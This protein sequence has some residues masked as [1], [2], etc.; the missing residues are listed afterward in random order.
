MKQF[1]F[2]LIAV[3]PS[4]LLHAQS[5]TE[6]LINAAVGNVRNN[7]AKEATT[8]AMGVDSNMEEDWAKLFWDD[9]KFAPLRLNGYHLYRYGN[10]S[11]SKYRSGVGGHPTCDGAVLNSSLLNYE[12][13][14]ESIRSCLQR[15]AWLRESSLKL[16]H[17]SGIN[18]SSPEA[19]LSQRREDFSSLPL[20]L[21]YRFPL[22]ATKIASVDGTSI[23]FHFGGSMPLI[24]A[25][26]LGS[27]SFPADITLKGPE[28]VYQWDDRGST[29][30]DP[31]GR[32]HVVANMSQDQINKVLHSNR[33][34]AWDTLFYTIQSVER[35]PSIL[36]NRP[37]YEIHITVDRIEIG[38]DEGYA[39][40][41]NM[42][43]L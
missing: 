8:R 34:V 9:D 42:I 10:S 37:H 12:M 40:P 4:P 43:T 24:G 29:R 26:S 5:F 6:R 13:D 20:K 36:G 7:I 39:P 15:E 25:G 30:S 1:L 19:Y 14:A 28:V 16:G 23:S 32:V 17:Q 3:L 41:T 22:M 33:T 11:I 21:Y 18:W 35:V 2:L 31:R 38:L 27:S